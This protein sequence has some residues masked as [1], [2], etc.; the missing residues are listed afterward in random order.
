MKRIINLLL[1]LVLI[2]LSGCWTKIYLSEQKEREQES[3]LKDDEPPLLKA[4]KPTVISPGGTWGTVRS[5]INTNFSNINGT[6]DSIEHNIDVHD[7]SLTAHRIAI[8]LRLL[9]SDTTSMLQRYVRQSALN[10]ALAGKQNTLVPGVTIKTINNQSPLGSGNIEITGGGGSMIYPSSGIPTSTGSA[11]G[12]SIPN[13]SSNWDTAY[14]ERLRW[15]G[16]ST[17]LNAATART[18]LGLNNVTNESKATMFTNPQFTG[19]AVRWDNDTLATRAEARAGGGLTA[20][21][22]GEQ[23]GDSIRAGVQL[24]DVALLLSDTSRML[25]SYARR[26]E[27]GSGGVTEVTVRQIVG[28]TIAER[29]RTAVPGLRLQDSTGNKTGNYMT[30]AG[31]TAMVNTRE[32]ALGNPSTSGYI[33]SST[34]AGV[35]SWIAPPS[36]SMVYPSGSGIP[37][38]NSGVWGTTIVDN[39]A[40]WNTSYGWGNHRDAGYFVGTNATIRQLFSESVTGLTYTDSTGVLSLTS[41]YLIPTTTQ[42]SAWNDAAT[43]F[44][45]AAQVGAQ[46]G[47][48]LRSARNED[49]KIGPL[50]VFGIGSGHISDTALF[51]NGRIAGGW[52]N[53]GQDTLYVTEVRGVLVEGTGTET[54]TCDVMWDVSR[55]SAT[56]THLVATGLTITSTTTGT[57]LTSFSNNMIL[58]G[59]WVWC[60]LSGAS[61]N[62]KPTMLIL[63]LTGYKR[64]RS[65]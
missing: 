58:P 5:I 14:S 13:N 34:A 48:S 56:A 17:G 8:N 53:S 9:K 63:Q 43:N 1:I 6:L 39:S 42:A 64:N 32:A 61:A 11:W 29:L 24:G 22:V 28:D 52:H 21:Q 50:F 30:R 51:N 10:T 45:S 2:G 38:V 65:N 49:S 18:S 57:V 47:D 23:I 41:G 37:T 31:T 60:T 54:I 16:G 25:A 12:T 20:Q 33:L 59:R 26:S 4:I 55:G 7:D 3:I 27:L 44:R 40:N 46:I 36:G 19:T 62:N 15:D 35:R